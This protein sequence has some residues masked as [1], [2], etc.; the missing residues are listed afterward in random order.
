MRFIS[1]VV[2]YLFLTLGAIVALLLRARFTQG[3]RKKYPI[4]TKLDGKQIPLFVTAVLFL[5][6]GYGASALRDMWG[7]KYDGELSQGLRGELTRRAPLGET[8][9]EFQEAAS[10]LAREAQDFFHAAERDFVANR[11]R[12]AGGGYRKSVK[13]LP[14]MSGYL[15]LGISL[16]YV[17]ALADAEDAFGRGLQ[18]AQNKGRKDFQ[19]AFL[20]NLGNVYL[21]QGRLEEALDY[22]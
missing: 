1:I 8:Q 12:D 9:R 16:L 18:L 20:L 17:S 15:N 10:E 11:Y 4:I 19:Q 14:T 6:L 5:V 21:D 2:G 13:T 3:Q 22:Q 7:E